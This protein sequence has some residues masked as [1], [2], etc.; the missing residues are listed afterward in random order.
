MEQR[1]SHKAVAVDRTYIGDEHLDIFRQKRIG[2]DVVLADT[3]D[4]R[5]VC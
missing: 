2:D 1:I 4:R 3:N 5:R